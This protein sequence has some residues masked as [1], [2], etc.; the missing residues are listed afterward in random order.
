M[1]KKAFSIKNFK[2]G[3]DRRRAEIASVP[4]ALFIGSDGHINTGGEFEKRKAIVLYANTAILDNSGNQGT[5]GLEKTASALVTFGSA[6]PFGGAAPNLASA[7]PAGITY[8]QLKHPAVLDGVTYAAGSH[9]MTVLVHSTV[10]NGLAWAIATFADG[11]SFA[12]YNGALIGDFVAG[13]ILP[14]QST[15]ALI[16]TRIAALINETVDYAATFDTVATVSRARTTNVATLVTATHNLS[17]G[18]VVSITGLGGTGYNAANVTVTV[19]TSTSFTY[20]NTGGDEGTTA[21]TG[22][23]VTKNETLN[24]TGP[25]G[26]DY[27]ATFED[28]SVAGTVTGP[29]STTAPI[30]P[31]PGVSAAGSFRITGGSV[32]GKATGTLTSTGTIP[33]DG[34]TVTIGDKVYTFKT[35]LTPTEGQVLINASAANALINLGRAINHSGTP[36][37]D[38]SVAAA[39][40]YVEAG[41]PTA[42]TLGVT[43]RYGGTGGNSIATTETST[44]LSWGAAT[45]TGGTGSATANTISSITVGVLGG[46]PT[47][48]LSAA[49]DFVN[50]TVDTATAVAAAISAGPSTYEATSDSNTVLIFALDSANPVPNNY[51][52]KVTATGDVCCGQFLMYFTTPLGT[53]ELYEVR[54]EGVNVTTYSSGS[55]LLLSALVPPTLEKFYSTLATNINAGTTAGLAHGIIAHAEPTYIQLSRRITSSLDGPAQVQV[56]LNSGS[57]IYDR[58]PDPLGPLTMV[59]PDVY[60]ETFEMGIGLTGQVTSDVI[61]SE[62]GGGRPDYTYFWRPEVAGGN[63]HTGAE[64]QLS[65]RFTVEVN[66]V[67]ATSQGTKFIFD[68]NPSGLPYDQPE[69]NTRYGVWSFNFVCVVT[70]S[71]GSSKISNTLQININLI[72]TT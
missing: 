70:D 24:I 44:Q 14:Y 48:L 1:A 47:Q 21:D 9:R 38:Y 72:P 5:F 10:F 2:L 12:Y 7:M 46:V 58:V 22:G 62:P 43:A 49:V 42:T 71:A 59:I 33:A 15:N 64:Q 32:G 36:G 34:D 13:I 66:P 18:M 37:T 4:G 53:L 31:R 56:V 57:V 39:N 17:T 63:V 51:E 8:Q 50:N 68:A 20:P 16:A 3:L 69:R 61:V 6:N 30:P 25:Q 41:T 35:A 19:L 40:A 65:S 60:A 45:L 54:V 23:T 52:V 26:N 11:Y 55:S 67:H 28:T 29:T 27:T